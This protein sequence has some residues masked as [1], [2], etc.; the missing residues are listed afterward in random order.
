[1]FL[2]LIAAIAVIALVAAAVIM[3]RARA[4]G[5]RD[6]LAR[7]TA[8]AQARAARAEAQRRRVLDDADDELTSVIPAIRLP[9]PTQFSGPRE[10]GY[11]ELDG[12][13]P[14]FSSVAP[15]QGAP[16]DAAPRFL[17]EAPGAPWRPAGRG[18]ADRRED[19]RLI[20]P[21][22]PEPA[23]PAQ[24]PAPPAWNDRPLP[25][26]VPDAR[27]APAAVP[28]ELAEHAAAMERARRR[29]THGSHRGGHARRRR[30]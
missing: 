24:Y 23:G 25:V 21:A 2:L 18:Q 4:R 26:P 14:Q 29:P 11:R 1:M 9:W 7:Q 10:P 30:G 6:Q 22:R 5:R 16:A 19:G 28:A 15:F 20:P 17:E 3:T 12:D 8:A 13:Y 27:M